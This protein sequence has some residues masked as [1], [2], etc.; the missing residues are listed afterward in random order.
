MRKYLIA[1]IL[2]TSI[3]CLLTTT[4]YSTEEE[5]KLCVLIMPFRK[6]TNNIQ[7]GCV[8]LLTDLL[9]VE[10]RNLGKITILNVDDIKSSLTEKEFES[11]IGCDDNMCLLR[12]VE[13]LA[14]NKLIR[15]EIWK[16]GKSYS[17]KLW[18]IDD[19]GNNQITVEDSFDCITDELNTV[20]EL[21]ALKFAVF[22]ESEGKYI[23][24]MPRWSEWQ[25]SLE[26]AYS[27]AL[28]IDSN[29]SLSA[30][31][32]KDVWQRLLD[33]FSEDNPDSTEDQLIRSI[34][35]KRLRYWSNYKG[36]ITERPSLIKRN[37]PG[38]DKQDI[39][40]QQV[41]LRSYY[42]KLS[43]LQAHHI[44]NMTIR[45]KENWGF[46][47]HSKINHDYEVKTVDDNKIVV[48]YATG[49]MWHES[50]SSKKMTY[51]NSSKWVSELNSRG[52]AGYSDWRLPTVEE[53]ASLLEP[54]ENDNRNNSGL[55]IDPVFDQKQLYIW[56][57]DT[58]G[59]K[60]AWNVDFYYFGCVRCYYFNSYFFVR[61]VRSN[62]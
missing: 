45:K 34:A 48:D 60:A 49:L 40:K 33:D 24:T 59:T 61:P 2:V 16:Q 36:P 31:K 53:A 12:N 56:T 9:S 25:E 6:I 11:A 20:A 26:S 41:R 39:K 29:F 5:D 42:K 10:I 46:S 51:D 55:Y 22:L 27:K 19:S 1:Q 23:I 37:Q 32:I 54:R 62:K 8:S 57:G 38:E 44:S 13:K 14:V 30:D 50:G 7:E 47:G 17:A 18:L 58:Y 52:Y 28:N 15:G 21:M 35:V 4:V 43:L 3:T